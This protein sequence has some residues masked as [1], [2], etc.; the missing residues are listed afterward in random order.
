MA[1]KRLTGG[2]KAV[3]PHLGELRK[4][5]VKQKKV[6]KKGEEYEIWGKDTDHFRFTSKNDA[7]VIEFYKL[8]PQDVRSIDVYLPY[9]TPAENFP[10]WME[11]YDNKRMLHRCDGETTVRL[12]KDGAYT[13]EP[14]PCPGECKAVG[15]L[16]VVLVE[17]MKQGFVGETT[18][19]THSIND[20]VSIDANLR[21]Y[22]EQAFASGGT[23]KGLKFIL[24]REP[25]EISTPKHGRQTKWLLYLRPETEWVK[26]QFQL[27]YNQSMGIVSPAEVMALPPG[28]QVTNVVTQNNPQTIID[29]DHTSDIEPEGELVEE[30]PEPKKPT[31]AENISEINRLGEILYGDK[32]EVYRKAV[33]SYYKKGA[34]TLRR[35]MAD[36][37][38]ME[39][40]KLTK[41]YDKF[42]GNGVDR[43]LM[44]KHLSKLRPSSWQDGMLDII[45]NGQVVI[46]A[47][48]VQSVCL[49][50]DSEDDINPA[51]KT[52]LAVDDYARR[53][54]LYRQE[55]ETPIV[56][57][58]P[59]SQDD[60]IISQDDD[61]VPF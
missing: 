36:H 47:D 28:T 56:N 54:K 44:D 34:T 7:H 26:A 5:T 3:F 9:A 37:L 39:L 10:N 21:Y 41:L 58:D 13:D 20:I 60:Q 50:S 55:T 53:I 14:Y 27:Q 1:I 35:L 2:K 18:V 24:S 6:N 32:W 51:E 29:N 40:R 25:K 43:K 16:Q 4:G 23:L 19:L 38:S 48:L 52:A 46:I 61:D 33:C 45:L 22:Y 57:Q 59:V 30:E 31:K 42:T 17:L 12:W 11:A 8:Y 15:R 49:L